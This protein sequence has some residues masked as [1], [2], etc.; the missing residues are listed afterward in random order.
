MSTELVA[1]LCEQ[2]LAAE[3]ADQ[4]EEARVLYARAWDNAEHA[5]DRSVAAHYRARV[6]Q[7]AE[8]RLAW[9]RTSVECA[10]QVAEENDERIYPLL[11]TLHITSAAA[12]YEVGDREGAREQYLAAARALR[13]LDDSAPQA[14][15]LQ[16]VIYEGLKATG[17]VAPGSCREVDDFIELLQRDN[18]L[19][20]LAYVLATRVTGCGTADHGAEFVLA[21]RELHDAGVLSDVQQSALRSA[22]EAAQTLVLGD[23]HAVAGAS[24]SDETT[25][26]Q[27]VAESTKGDDPFGDG[28]PNVALRI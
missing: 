10:A 23:P 11:P 26:V 5:F 3:T 12:L 6:V 25:P 14:A 13:V 16:S 8:E 19:G 2:G 24:A 17:Y 20:P 18:A 4:L 9:A 21:L 27:T 1:E 7:S 15:L 22:V 28:S